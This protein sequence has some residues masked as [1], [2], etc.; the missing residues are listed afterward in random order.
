MRESAKVPS[1]AVAAGGTLLF[2]LLSIQFNDLKNEVKENSQRMFTM[3]SQMAVIQSRVDTLSK[4]ISSK[5][6]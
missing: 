1:W 6:N 4:Q 5:E 3:N 2:A